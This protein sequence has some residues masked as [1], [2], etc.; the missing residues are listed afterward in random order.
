MTD[1]EFDAAIEGDVLVHI[2]Q[3]DLLQRLQPSLLKSYSIDCV[4]TR[5]GRTFLRRA[6]Q[7]VTLTEEELAQAAR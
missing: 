7:F 6:N 3:G 2:K 1:A 5:D 4:Y